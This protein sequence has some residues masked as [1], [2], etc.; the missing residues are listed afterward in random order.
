M[1]SGTKHRLWLHMINHMQMQIGFSR[2]DRW[3][4]PFS[5]RPW[6]YLVA[7]GRGRTGYGASEVGFDLFGTVGVGARQATGRH[8]PSAAALSA[9][10]A[11]LS[12]QES[13]TLTTKARAR[14]STPPRGRPNLSIGI[15]G[16]KLRYTKLWWAHE[17]PPSSPLHPDGWLSPL[18]HDLLLRSTAVPCPSRLDAYLP[19]GLG[20]TAAG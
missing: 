15:L 16:R 18:D 8:L 11:G 5:F 3:K 7:W 14:G 20:S 10:C 12:F 19:H 13:R 4:H 17:I 2:G 1:T 6:C 9:L